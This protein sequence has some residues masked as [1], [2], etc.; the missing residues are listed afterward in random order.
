VIWTSP[1]P[2][3][4]G[5]Q[6][7]VNVTTFAETSVAC[8]APVNAQSVSVMSG[9]AIFMARSPL[10]FFANESNRGAVR[11]EGHSEAKA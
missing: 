3:N 8:A 7:F 9:G 5:C 11:I 2:L 6:P 1:L 10:A 4:P